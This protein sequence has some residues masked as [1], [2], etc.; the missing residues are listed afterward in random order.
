MSTMTDQPGSGPLRTMGVPSY[1]ILDPTE[2]GRLTAF[3]LDEDRQYA[4][5]ADVGGDTPFRAERPF[6]VLVVPARL[7]DGLR[8]G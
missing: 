6:A 8:P 7:L 2:P 1:W 5:V 3:E 4:E